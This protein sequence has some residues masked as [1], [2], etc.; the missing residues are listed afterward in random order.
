MNMIDLTIETRGFAPAS[1]GIAVRSIGACFA[2]CHRPDSRILTGIGLLIVTPAP[3]GQYQFSTLARCLREDERPIDLLDWLETELPTVDAIVSWSNWG[4]VPARIAALADRERHPRL[5]SAAADT[6]GR[7]R[8]LPRGHV[9][10]LRQAR[11]QA[12]PCLC[13]PRFP[14][15]ECRREMPMV[16]LPDPDLTAHQLIAEATAGWRAWAQGF[17]AL[18]ADHPAQIALRSLNAWRAEQRD[19]D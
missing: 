3:T 8:V 10:H 4:S 2:A 5:V 17:G 1:V 11:A 14:V 9:W 6:A 19:A 15:D 18:D 16:L 12:M 7:W 13:P